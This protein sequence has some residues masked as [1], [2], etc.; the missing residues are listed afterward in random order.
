MNKVVK[1]CTVTDKHWMLYYYKL[2][3][4]V[5]TQFRDLETQG[6]LPTG[7]ENFHNGFGKH[8]KLEALTTTTITADDYSSTDLS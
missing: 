1:C 5:S 4:K 7:L 3:K 2:R 6:Q 8:Q